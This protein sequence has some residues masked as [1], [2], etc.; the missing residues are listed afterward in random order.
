VQDRLSVPWVRTFK[1]LKLTDQ[2]RRDLVDFIETLTGAFE[3][4]APPNLP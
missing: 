4:G 3:A 1:P 2:G